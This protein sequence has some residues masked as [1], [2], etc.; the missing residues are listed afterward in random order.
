MTATVARPLSRMRS[1]TPDCVT[2]LLSEIAAGDRRLEAEVYLSDGFTA[3]RAIRSSELAV[4]PLGQLARIWQPTRLKANSSATRARCTV[5]RGDP[6]VRHLAYAPEV[7]CAQ[8][9]TRHFGSLCVARLHSRH[10][11]G[12]GWKRHHRLFGTR[13]FDHL[14]RSSARGD[15]RR[16]I[17]AE[18]RVHFPSYA[19]RA[20]DDAGNPLR[21]RHKAS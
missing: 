14:G 15:R 4:S 20:N 7:A 19:V 21:K 16:P 11:I 18:V 10:P 3:R 5:S 9:D 8:Q 17:V 2:M 12:N 1:L 13:Q 6:G